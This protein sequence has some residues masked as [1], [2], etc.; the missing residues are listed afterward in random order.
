MLLI[1]EQVDITIVTRGYTPDSFGNSV[2]RLQADRTDQVA[3]RDVLGSSTFDVVYDNICYTP[4][5]AEDA[6]LLFEGRTGKYIV[7]SSLSVYPFGESPKKESDFDPY[8]YP[9]RESYPPKGDY[10]EGKRIVE[11]VMFKKSPFAVA[12][13]RFP[14]VLGHDDYTRRLHFHVE[15]VQQGI[16][17]GIPNLNARMSFISSDERPL[18]SP[19]SVIPIW[20]D[21]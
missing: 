20:K 1:R 11:A 6:V 13:V 5:E 8:I 19:G 15:H 14:I 7:T 12:A 2:K 17:L 10:A 4:Q 18:F 16:P 21:R 9:L 3:L